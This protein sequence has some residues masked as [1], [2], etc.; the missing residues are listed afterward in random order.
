MRPVSLLPIPVLAL[1]LYILSPT[2]I[3]ADDEFCIPTK[4]K[5]S[6]VIGQD[7]DSI[8]NYTQAFPRHPPFGLMAY[9]A[10]TSNHSNNIAGL[11]Q[12]IEYGSGIEWAKGLLD[13]YKN[14]SLQLGLYMVNSCGYIATGLL[15][16]DIDA[17]A[18]F[19]KSYHDRSIYLRIGYEFDSVENQYPPLDYIAAFQR[20]VDRFND[21]N[22]TNTAFVWH[23]SGFTPR[24]GHSIEEW[25]PGED[26]VDW[27][28]VSLFQ[29]PYDCQTAKQCRFLHAERLVN[30]CNQYQLPVMIAESTPFGG[31]VEQ[32]STV[33][34]NRAG[35]TGSSWTRWF[36]PVL[37]FIERHDVKMWSYINCDW[38]SFPMWQKNHA[39]G[40]YWGDTRIEV[41]TDL[42]LRWKELILDNPRFNWSDDAEGRVDGCAGVPEQP[43]NRTR[44]ATTTKKIKKPAAV[45]VFSVTMLVIGF[46]ICGALICANMYE[47]IRQEIFPRS[48]NG[49]TI[50]HPH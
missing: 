33:K 8:S 21:K 17:L 41:T 11:L 47:T 35:Y 45:K 32:L 15:D 18:T 26:Y 38:D 19:L 36:L 50:I 5:T 43:H 34:V 49:Y 3:K 4:G 23:A 13:K 44:K 30:F 31:I 27:C 20:I 28:G 25:F 48:N 24:D 29:Q 10:L 6:L 42:R 46:V 16:E 14:A 22:V 2:Y 9:T 40:I 12:P 7:L 1:I 39:P 37:T